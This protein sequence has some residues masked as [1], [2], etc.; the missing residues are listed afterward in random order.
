MD[1]KLFV[2]KS[3]SSGHCPKCNAIASLDR[4]RMTGFADKVLLK[5][6]QF[7]S[8]HCRV[9]KWEGK[10]FLYKVRNNY[11]IILLKYA[12][13][14]ISSIIFIVLINLILKK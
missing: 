7:R 8:Y 12:I 4:V 3:V 2:L 9:C 6:F 5:I 10:V 11:K 14:I 13:L 1:L